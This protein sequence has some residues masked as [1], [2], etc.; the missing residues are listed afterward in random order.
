[1]SSMTET[2]PIT[3]IEATHRISEIR[4]RPVADGRDG[5]IAFVSCRYHDVLLN[6]VAVRRDENGR[7][8]LTWPRKLGATGRPHPLHHP[9]TKEAAAAFDEAI[10]GT[11]NNLLGG[12]SPV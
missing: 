1:M 5:L 2:T 11:L 12:M 6:D 3:R 8:H 9:L 7:L 10:L 4:I